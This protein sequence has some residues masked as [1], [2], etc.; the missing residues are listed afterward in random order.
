MPV[1]LQKSLVSLKQALRERLERTLT[2]LRA[3][4]WS[5][6]LCYSG[7]PTVPAFRW[8]EDKPP[9][10]W[11]Q[12]LELDATIVRA[13]ARS[14]TQH[15]LAR[16]SQT[17]ISIPDALNHVEQNIDALVD[18]SADA[19]ATCVDALIAKEYRVAVLNR[20]RLAKEWPWPLEIAHGGT[21]LHA[22]VSLCPTPLSDEP[23]FT[24]WPK[25]ILPPQVS[26]WAEPWLETRAFPTD[27]GTVADLLRQLALP[28]AIVF[29]VRQGLPFTKMAT[30]AL[31]LL[32]RLE[33]DV[34]Q[35][36]QRTF[37]AIDTCKEHTKLVEAWRDLP[38][39]KTSKMHTPITHG[40]LELI[41]PDTNDKRHFQLSLAL[42]DDPIASQVG[43]ALREWRSWAGLRHW[44]AFQSLLTS[45]RRLGWVRWTLDDHLKAMGYRK[46]PRKRR[47]LRRSTAQMVELFTQIEI[48]IYDD[49]GRIRERRP[50]VHKGSTYERLLGSEW[51][52]EGLELKINPLLYRGVRDPESGKIGANWWPTPKELPYIDHE[53]HGAAIALGATLPARWR[54]ELAKSGN[55][56]I[57]LRGD[58]LLRAA[59]LPYSQKSPVTTWRSVDRNL[60]EL[61]RRGGLSRWEWQGQPGLS[62]LCRLYAP[63]WAI[64]RIAHGVTPKEAKP[65][66]TALT[67]AELKA[68]RKSETLTQPEAAARLRLGVSTVKRAEAQPNKPLSKKVREALALHGS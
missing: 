8:N 67:G 28:M 64:D 63:T 55:T 38:K 20:E 14:W 49:K 32:Y 34:K 11:K 62:T 46:E 48:A 43:A 68:W 24:Q 42:P 39:A 35:E 60:A 36:Q 2:H 65:A 4:A 57:D 33:D 9:W 5:D 16:H 59:G 1:D 6:A 13:Q 51:E 50:L 40:R 66:P 52:L 19:I 10:H 31:A 54:W 61:R 15:H 25:D 27:D 30:P 17:A 56:H 18:A 29:Q 53:K 21:L 37:I 12:L 3:A 47:K 45:N 23:L 26:V 44:V 41:L 58:S 7:K 22:L